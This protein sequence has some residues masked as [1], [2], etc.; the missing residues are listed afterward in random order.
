[1]SLAQHVLDSGLTTRVRCTKHVQGSF[2]HFQF[3]FD[4]NG[5]FRLGNFC[6]V[7]GVYKAHVI[8]SVL[9]SHLPAFNASKNKSL[10]VGSCIR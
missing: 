10:F 4:A 6:S 7:F 8:G 3:Y 2:L 9:P 1:M 5:V